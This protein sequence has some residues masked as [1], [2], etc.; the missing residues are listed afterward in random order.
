M[1]RKNSGLFEITRLGKLKLYE[2][3]GRRRTRRRRRSIRRKR[4][5]KG[6]Q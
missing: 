6:I 2:G 1:K 3:N 5:K 4:R